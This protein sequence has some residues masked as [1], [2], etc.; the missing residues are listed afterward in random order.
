MF[1]LKTIYPL[2]HSFRPYTCHTFSESCVTRDYCGI[3]KMMLGVDSKPLGSLS[4]LRTQTGPWSDTASYAVCALPHRFRPLPCSPS[5]VY[6]CIVAIASANFCQREW[7]SSIVEFSNTPTWPTAP[8]TYVFTIEV[9][10]AYWIMTC[11]DF[12]TRL[13]GPVQGRIWEV[14]LSR[15]GNVRQCCAHP[16]NSTLLHLTPPYCIKPYITYQLA[17]P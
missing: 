1:W 5:D 15:E 6:S 7:H 13:K 10:Q 12:S 17:P 16:P 4:S 14:A 3:K 8:G 2:N 9:S 11:N